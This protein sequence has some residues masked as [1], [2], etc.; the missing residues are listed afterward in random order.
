MDL[1]NDDKSWSQSLHYLYQDLN[2]ADLMNVRFAVCKDS[3]LVPTAFNLNSSN[4]ARI[5]EV[6]GI[7]VW[8]L[9]LNVNTKNNMFFNK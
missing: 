2:N 8:I 6:S 9:G 5:L 1:Y 4:E 7:G 3:F